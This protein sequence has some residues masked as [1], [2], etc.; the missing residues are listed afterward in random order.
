MSTR[1]HLFL[2]ILGAIGALLAAYGL[3]YGG[4]NPVFL[5]GALVVVLAGVAEFRAYRSVLSP[6]IA[7]AVVAG[8]FV[9]VGWPTL[10]LPVCPPSSGAVVSLTRLEACASSG[11][12]ERTL[13]ALA[14]FGLAAVVLLA[15]ALRHRRAR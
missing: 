4:D 12:R 1:R 10:S 9:V 14:G 13:T 15:L 7:L 6:L 11:A 3:S 8:F 2:V 5:V